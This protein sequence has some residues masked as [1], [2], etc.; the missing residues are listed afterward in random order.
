MAGSSNFVVFDP[1]LTNAESDATYQAD[2]AVTGGFASGIA[3]TQLF[4]KAFHQFS[5]MVAAIAGWISDKGGAASDA[6]VTAL[7][8]AFKAAVDAEALGLP[9]A[10]PGATAASRYVGATASGAPASGTFAVG[11]FALDQTGKIWVCTVAGTPGT[12]VQHYPAP[13]PNAALAADVARA[14]ILTNGG[15]EIFQRGAGPYTTNNAYTADR[16]QII[17]GGTS[18]ISV[19]QETTTIDTQG[20]SALKA[21]YTQG[22]ANSQIDQKV[23]NYTQYRGQTLSFSIRV[24]Q[25][26][27]SNIRPYISDSG[28][29]TYGVASATT[30][31]YVTLTVTLAIGAASTGI[32]AGVDL[33]ASDTVYLDNAMLVVGSV[34]CN[35]VPLHPEEEWARC[36]RYY[37]Y[38]NGN[39][40]GFCYS[41]T[42][43]AV[44]VP[45][46]GLMAGTPTVS[47]T[48]NG[49][50]ADGAS[51]WAPTGSQWVQSNVDYAQIY[52]IGSG[53][54]QFHP[55]SVN[56][57]AFILEVNP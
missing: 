44:D 19:T 4:N 10:L 33:G 3:S 1:N 24:R 37:R 6:D 55:G 13:I 34:P 23:E 5:I 27:A 53:W 40:I 32:N 8:G 41:G 47:V 18:T 2:S 45:L 17:L 36:K 42:L 9:L 26:V 56:N 11:D 28:V 25:G 14:N 31:G 39:F 57:L 20:V 49:T 48:A 16:W 29:K 54:T 21:V 52:L 38:V 15:Y 50:V 35:Y 46:S 51:S 30:G 22:T 12:W 43:F 7:K